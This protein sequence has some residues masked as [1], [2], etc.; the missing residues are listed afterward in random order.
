ML[1]WKTH[2]KNT[3]NQLR[4]YRHIMAV[5]MKYGF[6]DTAEALRARFKI[7]FGERAVPMYVGHTDKVHS[8]PVRLR[9]A[10]EELGPTF[11]KLGQLLSTRPDLIPHEYIKELEK[12]QDQVAPEKPEL[13][14]DEIEKELG[15]KI[16]AIFEDFDPI[17]LAA[18]SIAQVHRAKT[19][20]GREVVLKVR[21]PNIV[22][23]IRS[24]C[25]LLE[26]LALLGRATI[27]EKDSIDPQKMVR[28]LVRCCFKRSGFID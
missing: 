8:R 12:L 6:E 28:E 22:E 14:I 17:P 4:R 21:R 11:I 9:M 10:L 26:D 27:F 2:I 3:F 19:R 24:E 1:R 18:G 20:D 23:I 25:K 7:R 15:G 5:L 13:I 16:N